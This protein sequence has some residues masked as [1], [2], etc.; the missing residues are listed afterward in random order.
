MAMSLSLPPVTRLATAPSLAPKKALEVSVDFSKGAQGYSGQFSDYPVFNAPAEQRAQ[1][2]YYELKSGL[3]RVPGDGTGRTAFKLSGFNHSDD[4]I[5]SVSGPVKGL[6]PGKRYRAT[7]SATFATNIPTGLA[8]VGGAPGES[9]F[10]KLGLTNVKPA[11]L[12]KEQFGGLY[13]SLNIDTGIQATSG[14]DLK[15]VGHVGDA[16]VKPESPR[17]VDKTVT[18]RPFV[19]KATGKVAHVTFATDSGFE[20]S[21]TVFVRGLKVK[22]E[23]VD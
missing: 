7:V 12:K 11:V 4:L 21:S 23:P 20:G 8:G 6:V 15:L 3:A 1:I 22:L 16:R 2:E 5:M 18:M 9:V 13:A 14:K 10:V 19:F 17:F